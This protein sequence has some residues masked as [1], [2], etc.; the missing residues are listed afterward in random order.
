MD[1]ESQSTAL[2]QVDSLAIRLG[3]P[4]VDAVRGVSFQIHPGE[5]LGMAGE[6]GSGKSVT[7]LSLARLLPQAARPMYSG[8]VRMQ[9]TSGNLLTLPSGDLAGIRGKRIGYVFQEPSSSFNPV[10]TIRDHLQE[11]LQLCHIPRDHRAK[12][13]RHS[14]ESVGIQNT[15][16]NLHAYPS[17][18][19][20]GMLQR[21]AIACTLL[22]QPDLLIADEPTT[23]LDTSTQKRIVDLLKHLN[24]DRGMAILF[25]S[26][27]LALLKQIAGRIVVMKDG[28]V[29]ESGIASDVLYHP[30]HP[31][32]KSLV[33]AIPRL[34]LPD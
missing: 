25:I 8:S 22:A 14:L 21:L 34:K 6:S 30:Q 2:L 11:I 16:F 1:L 29:V 4:A 3:D 13:I 10:Y 9:G 12:A 32:T 31:Y 7:A 24:Q 27:D 26:H 33:A 19:S 28:R 18:F 17:D 20:G 15:D 5:I 23:A